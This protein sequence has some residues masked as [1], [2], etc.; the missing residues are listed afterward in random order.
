MFHEKKRNEKKSDKKHYCYHSLL[1]SS[2][3]HTDTLPSYAQA[4][5]I[6]QNSSFSELPEGFLKMQIS[7]LFLS[8]SIMH[9]CIKEGNFYTYHPTVSMAEPDLKPQ[10]SVGQ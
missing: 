4:R 10:P 8:K 2:L 6:S 3:G 7:G 9:I 1:H 5:S